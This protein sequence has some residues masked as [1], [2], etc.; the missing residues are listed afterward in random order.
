[1]PQIMVLTSSDLSINI[2][3]P[4]FDDIMLISSGKLSS[5]VLMTYI[6]EEGEETHKKKK[7]T[8]DEDSK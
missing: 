3:E 1:M 2:E 7:A 8:E 4:S 6:R 5:S